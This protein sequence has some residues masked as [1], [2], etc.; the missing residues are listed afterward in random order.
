LNVGVLSLILLFIVGAVLLTR[1]RD[2]EKAE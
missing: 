1:V 2:T